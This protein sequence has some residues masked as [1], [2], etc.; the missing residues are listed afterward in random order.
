[1]LLSVLI[2]VYNERKTLAT[3]LETVCGVLP[4]VDKELIVVDDC[5]TDGTRDWLRGNFPDGARSA[6]SVA[7]EANGNLA[8]GQAQSGATVTIRPLYHERNKGKGG[9]LQ[10]ALAVATGDV[11]VVQDADL[12]YDPQDWALMFDL[13]AERKVA[14]VVY[15]S[16]FYGRPHRSL[17]FHHYLANQPDL[18]GVQSAVQP[19]AHRRR[20][21]LQDVHAR[22]EGHSA[23]HLQRFRIRVANRRTD[24]AR[25]AL[26]HL[27]GRN[28]S[29]TAALTT[30]ARRSTGRTA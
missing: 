2:P 10:T 29:I 3:L 17:H 28:S 23:H 25:A 26:A 7:V 9:A 18:D 20:S 5:S 24:R 15:G 19:D 21:L 12:E 22:G 27:R 30:R 6:T 16:R 11:L 1:M 8:L 13:I 14:D 4:G